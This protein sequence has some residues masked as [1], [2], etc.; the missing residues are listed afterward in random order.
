MQIAIING[1]NLNLL[2]K[3]ETNIYGNEDFD[4]YYVQLKSQYTHFE[5]SYYQSNSEGEIV[6]KIQELGFGVD[7]IILN[8]AAYSHTSIAIRDAI[9]SIKVPVLEVHISN[10]YAREAFRNHSHISAV[11]VGVI[12]GLGLKGYN[13]ALDYFSNK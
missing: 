7:G 5:L 9:S 3:R 8:P 12:T 11:S 13:L 2:G 10:I 6:S 4:A 1:P